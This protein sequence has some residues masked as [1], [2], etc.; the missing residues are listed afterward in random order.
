MKQIIGFP[1]LKDANYIEE[2]LYISLADDCNELI[3]MLI[4]SINTSKQRLNNINNQK[5]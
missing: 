3:A 5:K 2:P 4:A 1:Y